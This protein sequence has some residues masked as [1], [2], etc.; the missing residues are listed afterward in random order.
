MEDFNDIKA[1]WTQAAP[2]QSVDASIV[3]RAAKMYKAR[4]ILRTSA[5]ILALAGALIVVS[6]VAFHYQFRFA[7]TKVG[8][9]LVILAIVSG[10]LMNS[11][12]VWLL[13]KPNSTMDNKT[14]L[15]TI[16]ALQQKE[17]YIQTKFL[18]LY[19]AVLSIGMMLYLFEF[20]YGG[21]L[22]SIIIYSATM[23]WI[24]FA[25]LYLRPRSIRKQRERTQKIIDQLEGVAAQMEE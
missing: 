2:K 13:L 15:K 3:I 14:F 8:I 10:M 11:Q 7:T 24:L 21:L 16:K 12:L 4:I 6:L 17:Q 22:F 1:L 5:G 20:T 9:A 25:W 23:G 18:S 19:F